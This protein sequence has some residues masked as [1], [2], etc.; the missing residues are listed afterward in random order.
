MDRLLQCAIAYQRMLNIEYRIIIGRK[1]TTIELQIPFES[2]NFHHLAGIHKLKDLEIATEN[3]N[4]V[5]KDILK[6]KITYEDICKSDFIS[7]STS[8][9]NSLAKIEMLFDTNNLIFRYNKKL[10][11]FSVIQADFIL[12]TPLDGNDIYIFLSKDSDNKYFCRSFFPRENADYTKGQT[13]YTL[14]YKEKINKLT[15]EKI[16]QYDRLTK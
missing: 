11:V 15:G 10:Q 1:G 14:L 3:R 12:S 8:R 5:F 9:L 13:K 6:S 2:T 16:V 4:K 7:D